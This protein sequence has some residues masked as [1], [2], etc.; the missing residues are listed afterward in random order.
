[1]PSCLLQDTLPPKLN[2][3]SFILYGAR[4]QFLSL[5]A[6]AYDCFDVFVGLLRKE[7]LNKLW[8]TSFL[9]SSLNG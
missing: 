6:L 1:M 2:C 4:V 3:F 9:V 5:S 7:G 8:L